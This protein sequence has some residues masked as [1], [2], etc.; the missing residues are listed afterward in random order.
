MPVTSAPSTA[1][2][3][4]LKLWYMPCNRCEKLQDFNKSRLWKGYRFPGWKSRILTVPPTASLN[5]H[6][7]S[8]HTHP[9][10]HAHI[11]RSLLSLLETDLTSAVM[12][13]IKFLITSLPSNN[14]MSPVPGGVLMRLVLHAY[15]CCSATWCYPLGPRED[16]TCLFA[17]LFKFNQQ[18]WVWGKITDSDVSWFTINLPWNVN[19]I[20]DKLVPY[21]HKCMDNTERVVHIGRVITRRIMSGRLN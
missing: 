20:W 5:T 10:V 14:L 13:I 2:N 8:Q 6:V 12:V 11:A 7:H 19:K 18:V 17:Y 21:G 16:F 1:P 15:F 3:S 9:S 4:V